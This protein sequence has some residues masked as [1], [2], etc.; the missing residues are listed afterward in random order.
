M[1][2]VNDEFKTFSFSERTLGQSSTTTHFE[3]V[4]CGKVGN[5][6]VWNL[7]FSFI[8]LEEK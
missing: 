5:K 8:Y 2:S 7:G 6:N 4:I 1:D 3:M